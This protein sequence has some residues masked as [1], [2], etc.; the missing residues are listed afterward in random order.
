MS[1]ELKDET[2]QDRIVIGIGDA[3]LPQGLQLDPGL[4][5]EKAKMMKVTEKQ[6]TQLKG[7][8]TA[9]MGAEI[10]AIKG[11]KFT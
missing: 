5:L 11:G 9:S 10:N 6:Q 2:I 1:G 4:T 8:A 7:V 3:Q